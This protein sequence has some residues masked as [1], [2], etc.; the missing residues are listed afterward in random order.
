LR[1]IKEV[2]VTAY[3]LN[4]HTIEEIESKKLKVIGVQYNPVSA[5]FNQVNP[6]LI[7]FS[8]LLGR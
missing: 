3:N 6:I 5:G 4:D 7:K 2:K 1:K 8:K